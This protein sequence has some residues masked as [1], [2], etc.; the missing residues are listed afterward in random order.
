MTVL[1]RAL[2]LSL[3]PAY[4]EMILAG[5]KT[6]ELRRVRPRAA[7]GT[8]AIVYASSPICHV[9][10]TCIIE[11]VSDG[12]PAEL[13]RLHGS[14]TGIGWQTFSAYFAD[15]D[16]RVAIALTSPRRLEDPVSLDALRQLLDGFAPPRSFRYLEIQDAQIL[17][18][19]GS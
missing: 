16:H 6:V 14:Q 1:D 19:T 17:L 13:W 3:R 2:F 9:L 7:A 18:G 15:T 8:L 5:S 4:A 10:G 11:D 12:T